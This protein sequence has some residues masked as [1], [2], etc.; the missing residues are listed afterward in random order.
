MFDTKST[1]HSAL[2][3]G[4]SFAPCSLSR[5][6]HLPRHVTVSL[7]RPCQANRQDLLDMSSKESWD[8]SASSAHIF[9]KAEADRLENEQNY[10]VW[11]VQMKNVFETCDMWGIV[12]GSETIPSDDTAHVAKRW[13]WIKKD[14]LAKAMITQCIKANLV[15][16]VAHA[17]RAKE[18]WDIFLSEFSQT[19]SG[20]IMLWFRHLTKQLPSGG[21]VST[22]VMGFQEAICYLANTKFNIPGYIAAAI[23]LSTL[24]SDPRDPHSWN[25]HVTGVKI[26]KDTTT[27]SSVVNGILEEK[28]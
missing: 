9:P 8:M 3:L 15:I 4:P 2:D 13:I 11:L 1:S 17:K 26:N 14:N 6:P 7:I 25:Q 23:L 24:P 5:Y 18:S 22:H 28:R 19:G 10:Y 21:N 27:L 12:N 16:K 20:L